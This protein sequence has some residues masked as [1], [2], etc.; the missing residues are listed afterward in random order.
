[1]NTHRLR[2]CARVDGSR[3][4]SDAKAQ[5]KATQ[6]G[7]LVGALALAALA[8]PS[9]P[10]S[11]GLLTFDW[12]G[13]GFVFDDG[14]G[15]NPSGAIKLNPPSQS[16]SSSNIVVNGDENES[17]TY[18]P[19][20]N[21]GS[22]LIYSNSAGSLEF[23]FSSNLNSGPASSLL[24]S[25]VWSS[26]DGETIEDA[27]TVVGGVKMIESA[28]SVVPEPSTWALLGVGFAGLALA[29]MRRRR[30]ADAAARAWPTRA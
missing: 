10:A 23:Q 3:S 14:A 24:E 26:S 21:E 11:A 30:G 8:T 9:A 7:A 18:T 25:V 22:S 19:S 13:A 15:G 4:A 6:R 17:A 2:D 27:S 5:G 20:K 1:M 12:S 28:T 29:G 16:F